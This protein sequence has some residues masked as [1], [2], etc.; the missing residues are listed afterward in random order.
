VVDPQQ[1]IS[2]RSAWRWWEL[3]NI[4]CFLSRRLLT[5]TLIRGSS[6]A[7]GW[8]SEVRTT[9]MMCGCRP[10]GMRDRKGGLEM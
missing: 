10:K 6:G 8:R 3:S 7:G 4:V 9:C 1:R 5:K 2:V